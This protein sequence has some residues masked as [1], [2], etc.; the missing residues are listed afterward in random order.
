VARRMKKL[1]GAFYDRM[2]RYDPLLD[3]RDP[4]ALAAEIAADLEIG[5]ERVGPLA[6]YAL[7]S[8]LTLSECDLDSM[9][10][11]PLFAP[12]AALATDEVAP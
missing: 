11:A 4:V 6:R 1:A 7:A 10:N 9:L 12:P 3:R 8:A 5:P 2:R